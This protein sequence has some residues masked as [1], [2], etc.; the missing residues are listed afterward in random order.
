M[1]VLVLVLVLALMEKTTEERAEET[2]QKHLLNA[3]CQAIY[4]LRV[5]YNQQFKRF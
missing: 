3:F 4:Q 1:L 5:L 2:R